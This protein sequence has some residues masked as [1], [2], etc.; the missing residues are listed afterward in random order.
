MTTKMDL[1]DMLQGKVLE[2][3]GRSETMV[4]GLYEYVIDVQQKTAA[5][6]TNNFAQ[7]VDLTHRCLRV[8]D[9]G[10]RILQQHL[11]LHGALHFINVLT[12]TRQGFVCVR[13]R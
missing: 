2:I 6:P 7:K 8:N 4:R 5:S 1:S 9:I 13:K 10:G 3:F 12:N 11:P